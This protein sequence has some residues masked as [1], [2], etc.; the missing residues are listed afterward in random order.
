ML[1]AKAEA[2]PR[3]E[4]SAR[5]L[6]VGRAWS[7]ARRKRKMS[8]VVV[9]VVRFESFDLIVGFDVEHVWL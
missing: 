5:D 4:R 8:G 3:R 6:M 2:V 7:T 9:E 1:G